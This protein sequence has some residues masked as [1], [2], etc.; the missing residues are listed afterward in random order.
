MEGKKVA[1][2]LTVFNR[3]EITLQGLRSLYSSIENQ[4]D[5]TFDIFMTDDGSTD[6]TSDSVSKEFP[7]IHIIKGNN[8]F[9]SGGMRTAWE[10][11][12]KYSEYDYYIW[13]N[14]DAKLYQDA[15]GTLLDPVIRLGD[16]IIVCGAFC[17]SNGKVS[18]GAYDKKYH[19]I[20]I[21]EN[22]Q[23][24]F[25][26]GNF[27][28]IPKQVY[29]KVGIISDFYRHSYGDWDYGC[30][31]LKN[32]IRLVLTQK[33]VGT[34][35]RHDA[36]LEPFLDEH[37]TLSERLK[38]LY[39]VKCD[40]RKTFVFNYLHVS[41]FHAIKVVLAQHIYTV[42]PRFRNFLYTKK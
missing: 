20:D 21:K 26:N 32:N 34:T 38:L 41:L 30:R 9:W 18:Y 40:V 8:L 25:M 13:F 33:Y 24:Y 42:F 5:Y 37:R 10:A 3:K 16:N 11:A 28:L 39:S 19:L 7:N 29:N 2:L 14:D 36:D 22:A 31:A 15:I 17:D 6:G 1:V 27:V 35:D 23:P 4:K 12:I